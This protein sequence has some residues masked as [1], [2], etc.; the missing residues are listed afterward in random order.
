MPEFL[1]F[2]NGYPS[3]AKYQKLYLIIQNT[4]LESLNTNITRINLFFTNFYVMW[5]WLFSAKWLSALIHSSGN[6]IATESILSVT[7]LFAIQIRFL[8]LPTFSSFELG[9]F[10][11]LFEIWKSAFKYTKLLV[12]SVRTP[13]R[14]RIYYFYQLLYYVS[15][16]VFSYVKLFPDSTIC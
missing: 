12:L 4:L 5:P 9:P 11:F 7:Y 13:N 8:I 14:V 10:H 6:F 3:F 1:N 2:A 15:F 16:T